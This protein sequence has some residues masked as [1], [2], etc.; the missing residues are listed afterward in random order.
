VTTR[1][2][3]FGAATAFDDPLVVWITA[4]IGAVLVLAPVL[5]LALSAAGRLPAERR[6][7]ILTTWRSWLVL[8]PA[9]VVPVLLGAAWVIGAA[10][11]LAVACYR[12]FA[13]VTG[14]FREHAISAVVVVAIAALYFAVLDHWYA[15]FVALGPLSTVVVAAVAILPDRPQGYIQRVA[16]GVLAIALFGAGLGHLAYFANDTLYRPLILW[17]VVGVEMNDV[18][19]FTSGRLFGRRKLCP[20]TSPGKTVAGAVGAFVGTTALVAFLGHFVFAGT[21]LAAP[22]HLVALGAIVSVAGQFGDLALSSIKRDVGVKDTGTLIPGHG[23]LLDRFDSLLL[24]APA[25][26]HYV[27]YFRPG[28]G[29]GQPA[30][31]LTGGG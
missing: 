11:I 28:V 8:A 21:P 9:I 16:L 15:F 14:L 26:F 20:N 31:I 2:R 24:A 18:F 5:V 22:V 29:L 4:A 7:K 6:A 30:R 3:L 27:G 23:G 1:E 19:A 10:L 13:R 12:E 25:V 17:L